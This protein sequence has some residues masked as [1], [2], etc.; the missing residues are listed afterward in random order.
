MHF[1]WHPKEK[2]G[3]LPTV[4]DD[5]KD[6]A[7]VVRASTTKSAPT[8]RP[9]T[10]TQD[11]PRRSSH[12]SYQPH[13]YR[14]ASIKAEKPQRPE[15]QRRSTTARTRYIDMLLGLDHVSPFHNILASLS[16]W[17]LLAGYIVFPA[18]FNKL[19][20]GNYDEKA[21]TDLKKHALETVRNVPLMYVAAF[22]CGLGVAGCLWLWWKHRKN[23][24][25]VINRIFLPALLN[26]I[27]GLVSTLVNIYSA[28]DG[29]YSVT[30]KVTVVVTAACSAVAA[31]LFLLYNMVMLK[32]VKRK[33]ERE[34]RNAERYDDG[35]RAS[36]GRA[37]VD[38]GRSRHVV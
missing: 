7:S 3:T 18:T 13:V 8:H 35:D 36:V 16:V 4:E 38:Q 5:R 12:T 2:P 9:S 34:I 17:I 26:S 23:Y 10:R 22:A 33:H 27:A 6:S 19:Q 14:G 24:V 29:Q 37:S 32:L 30:A 11:P 20:K 28:Q 31:L 1:P 21:D 15:L 25:W